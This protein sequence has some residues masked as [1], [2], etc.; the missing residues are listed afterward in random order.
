MTESPLFIRL[1]LDEDVSIFVAQLLRAQG[2]EVLTA[3]DAH[4]AD[5]GVRNHYSP[6]LI[7][8]TSNNGS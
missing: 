7:A 4:G 8:V 6:K 3:R 1:Y 5:K 2:F